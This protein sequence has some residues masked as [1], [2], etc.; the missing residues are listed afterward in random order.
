MISA[1]KNLRINVEWGNEN[2][3]CPNCGK[4]MPEGAKFCDKCGSSAD[5]TSATPQTDT[6][7]E[8]NKPSLIV[9]ILSAVLALAA[10]ALFILGNIKIASFLIKQFKDDG[11][12]EVGQASSNLTDVANGNGKSASATESDDASGKNSAVEE[13]TKAVT[14]D[15]T[16]SADH[17]EENY[18][19][20]T[21]MIGM[22]V[23]EMIEIF[24]EPDDILRGFLGGGGHDTAYIYDDGD[25]IFIASYSPESPYN[26]DDRD[27]VINVEYVLYGDVNDYV[28]TGMP[29]SV[30]SSTYALSEPV[31]FNGGDAMLDG[32][33]VSNATITCNGLKCNMLAASYE[34]GSNATID[35]FLITAND[36]RN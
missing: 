35:L 15:T 4:E 18:V 12:T 7:S 17:D 10:V 31:L 14:P 21:E 9:R 32:K 16:V 3:Y 23:N 29:Y 2:M 6:A 5:G 25:Y 24:G 33:Y 1:A 36:L 34:N 20:P 30:L 26:F 8:K 13:V 27:A 19:Y 28:Y 11:S 22:T